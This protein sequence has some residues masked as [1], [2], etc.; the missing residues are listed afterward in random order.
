MIARRAPRC[1]RAS[2][3]PRATRPRALRHSYIE[4]VRCKHK[5]AALPSYMQERLQLWDEHFAKQERQKLSGENRLEDHHAMSGDGK[6]WQVL[7]DSNS[8]GITAA[9]LGNS[10]GKLNGVHIDDAIVAKLS[11]TFGSQRYSKM[12]D[13]SHP[14]AEATEQIVSRYLTTV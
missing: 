6:L 1:W 2:T 11:W 10:D 13:L 12:L 5:A 3:R 9:Q 7:T 4:H 14:I 8:V